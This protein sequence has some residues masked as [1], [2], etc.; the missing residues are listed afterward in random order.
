MRKLIALLLVLVLVL[1][2]AT[3]V[4]AD[5]GTPSPT[6]S[7]E[8]EPDKPVD[9]VSPPTGDFILMLVPFMVL[10]LFGVIVSTKKLIMNH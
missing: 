6:G 9:P 8:P 1:S 10:G 3:V 7:T 4:F 2:L 5:D